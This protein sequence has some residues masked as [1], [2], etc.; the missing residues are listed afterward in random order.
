MII[1]LAVAIVLAVLGWFA[2]WCAEDKILDLHLDAA[3]RDRD[4]YDLN[5]DNVR[6]RVLVARLSGHPS[7][8]VDDTAAGF[9]RTLAAVRALPE[10]DRS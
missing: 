7:A 2:F 5:R 1:A 4:L 3:N 10:Q 9:A 8:I 6:L